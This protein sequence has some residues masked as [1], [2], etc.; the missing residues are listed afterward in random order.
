MALTRTELSTRARAAVGEIGP[1]TDFFASLREL[2]GRDDVLDL[3]F[4][5]PHEMPLDGL[6]RAISSHTEPRSVDWFAYKSNENEPREVIST[7]LTTEL[8]LDFAPEDVALTQGAFGAIALA[9]RL[10]GDAGDE[11]I[12]PTP[13]WFCYAPML[14]LVDMAP[15]KV[16]LDPQTYDLDLAAIERAITPRTRVV[17]VNSPANPTGRVYPRQ[18]LESL[19]D[20]LE[21]ASVRIGRRVWLLSDEPYR[22]IRFDGVPFVSPAACYPWTLVDYSYGKVLLAPGQ[23]LG[24][25]AL[26]PLLPTPE[27]DALRAALVPVQLSM[28]WGFPDA[29]MQYSVADLEDVSIDLVEL[30]R[31]RDRML[32]ALRSAGYRVT[33]PEGTFYLWGDAPGGDAAR[34]VAALAERDV[35]VMPGTLFE[36]PQ[37]FRISLTA[38]MGTIERALPAFDDVGARLLAGR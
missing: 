13:G 31:K 4:G 23:R 10:V 27:R 19:A 14:R 24:Y 33:R 16:P 30:T 12:L 29:I 5:N 8:G 37:H 1:V 35:Y 21:S 38:T 17:V 32:G 36:R 28:G 18:Q 26:S 6:V 20:L 3:T 7:A 25:L 11:A 2:D 34:F 22:R 15:V 9:L